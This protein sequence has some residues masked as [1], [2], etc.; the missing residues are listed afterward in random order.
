MFISD[1][2]Q[3]RGQRR[4]QLHQAEGQCLPLLANHIVSSHD[5][6][7]DHGHLQKN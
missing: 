4:L 3:T 5:G 6:K 7:G 1:W 2:H